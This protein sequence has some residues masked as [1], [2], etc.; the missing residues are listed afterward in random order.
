[1]LLVGAMHISLF[2][3]FVNCRMCSAEHLLLEAIRVWRLP[4]LRNPHMR[5]CC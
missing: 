1:M 4:E 3:S 5:L 2:R